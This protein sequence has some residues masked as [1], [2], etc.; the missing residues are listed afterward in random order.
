MR[1]SVLVASP[2]AALCTLCLLFAAFQLFP[3]G[4]LTLAW[5]DMKQQVL[6]LL[7]DLKHILN[8]EDGLFLNLANAAGMNFWGVFF[9]FLASPFSFLVAF[10]PSEDIFLLANVLV[11]LKMTLCA[12]T[13]AVF[14][15][16]TFGRRLAEPQAA[17]LSLLY[18]FGGYALLYYQNVVWL[19]VMALF[20]LLMLGSARLLEQ[21]KPGLYCASL[22]A[23]LAVH[24][25]LGCQMLFFLVLW[26][27]VAFLLAPPQWD[28]GKAVLRLGGATFAALLLSAVVWLPSFFQYLESARGV[29]L[30]ESLSSG[31]LLTHLDTTL[32][33]LLCTPLLFAAFP[34]LAAQGKW[35]DRRVLCT[36]IL[37]ILMILPLILDPINKMWHLGSYQAFPSRYGYSNLFLGLCL[38]AEAAAG[39][40]ENAN[41]LRCR[42]SSA[43]HA[44]L[45]GLL[46][47]AAAGVGYWCLTR[48]GEELTNY[49]KTLWGSSGSTRYTLLFVAP[50]LAGG[51]ALFF[52]YRSG[53]L[54][55]RA[56]SAGFCLL[57]AL[58]SV[59]SG[60]V[61]IG[62]AAN[63]DTAYRLVL[64]L[65]GRLD[66]PGVYRV[67][68]REKY[69]DVNLVGGLGYG[70]MSHYTSLTAQ[71]YLA[72]VKKA[73]YSSYWMEVNSAGGTEWTD[74]LFGNRY[75]IV[76]SNAYGAEERAVYDN[77]YFALVENPLPFGFGM[78][79][80]ASLLEWEEIPLL[81]RAQTQ[82]FLWERI[83]GEGELIREYEPSRTE[84]VLYEPG[85]GRV[86]VTRRTPGQ[87]GRLVYE[88]A[89]Q[90]TQSLYFDCFD[91]ISNSLTE[92]VYGSCAVA[93]NGELLESSY[94]S[95]QKNGLL[96]LG[97]FR[98]ETV[99]VSV[100]VGRDVSARSFGVFGLDL[101]LL[102]LA[103]SSRA[104]ALPSF[105]QEGS[106]LSGEVEASAGEVLLLPLSYDPGLRVT[107]NGEEVD[108][109]RV[110]DDFTAIPLEEGENTVVLTLRPRG[111]A[112]GAALSA[113]G[114]LLAAWVFAVLRGRWQAWKFCRGLARAAGTAFLLLFAAVLA[115]FY[116][117][118]LAVAV[119]W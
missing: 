73:G 36:G 89:V 42:R 111:L 8:G 27:G 30:L 24:Y 85:G 62:A 109:S 98:D 61:Y 34:A 77:G 87:D 28:R 117:F 43:P 6:P 86:T 88:I 81:S 100:S 116:L 90:G 21:G 25:Y 14:L 108:A 20:P 29:N 68:M 54:T 105:R 80:P 18:A 11:L 60:C 51:L 3:F 52:A 1:K 10:T 72:L 75:S 59:F 19:D 76:H 107:V 58:G 33:I 50:V 57:A 53:R 96:Y 106:T 99:L 56:F 35:R 13:F 37:F 94:P 74:A 23:V 83:F 45:V 38:L 7:L 104:G 118:P 65:E 102:S 66:E 40:N 78:T 92:A 9:F 119:I 67:K 46:C 5:C 39:E 63:S 12:F 103:L 91:R 112:A 32:P 17:A 101:E 47:L 44:V 69:F 15:E 110:L 16:Q 71:D 115:A 84:G 79:A 64:D 41:G 4:G 48:H 2:L 95:Q 49:V 31:D 97:T 82:Q 22:T 70:S 113:L 26:F 93:V 55:R 114:A